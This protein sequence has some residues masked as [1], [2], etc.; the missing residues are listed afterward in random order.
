M[1]TR[2]PR[3][4]AAAGCGGTGRELARFGDLGRLDAVLI[5]PIGARTPHT[6]GPVPPQVWPSASGLV[7]TAAALVPV[8]HVVGDLL[9]W[10]ATRSLPVIVAVRGATVGALTQVLQ[11][12]RGSLDF[13]TVM[14]VEVDL[15][16]E[17]DQTRPGLGGLGEPE[18]LGPWSADPQA[19]LKLLAAAREEL[20]RDLLLTAKISGECPDLPAAAR[21]A[22]GGG[23]R[24]LVVAGGVPAQPADGIPAADGVSADDASAGGASAAGDPDKR[25]W[26]AGPAIAPVTLA[27]LAQLRAAAGAGRVPD[28][29]L[30]AVGGVTGATGALAARAAGA[31]GVQLGTGLLTDPEML[32]RVHEALAGPNTPS[33]MTD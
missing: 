17:R 20:P 33:P 15:T 13:S 6:A 22:V 10:F 19:C 5:G 8:E 28:V 18:P 2:I 4:T 24:A 12:L 31:T 29:P 32:W 9:P 26:L 25:A 3:V 27:R 21:A 23:A 30:I 7:H 11:A 14:G 16:A 1:K